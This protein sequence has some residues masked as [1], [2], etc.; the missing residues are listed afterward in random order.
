MHFETYLL[1]AAITQL[2]AAIVTAGIVWRLVR[3]T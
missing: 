1:L 3:I 2:T